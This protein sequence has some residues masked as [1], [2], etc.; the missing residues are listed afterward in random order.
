MHTEHETVR[1]IVCGMNVL[2]DTLYKYTYKK[3]KYL[4][5]S[6]TCLNKFKKDPEKFL[7]V[8]SAEKSNDSIGQWT[9]PMHPEIIRSSPG[10]YPI[11]GMA[12]EPKTVIAQ[13]NEN[14]ELR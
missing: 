9:C 5:C 2:P 1:D 3:H 6:Y 7:T 14:P 8:S 13:H 12:L 4:F 11:C 10:S